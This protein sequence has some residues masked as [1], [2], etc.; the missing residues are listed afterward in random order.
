MSCAMVGVNVRMVSGA[1]WLRWKMPLLAALTL[2]T[3]TSC[4]SDTTKQRSICC[5][6]VCLWMT[7]RASLN[8]MILCVVVLMSVRGRIFTR[9]S[10]CHLVTVKCGAA[11]TLRAP[12]ITPHLLCWH[13]RWLRQNDS[14]CWKNTTGAACHSS[15]WQSVSAALRRAIT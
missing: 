12:A 1:M 4:A 9:K 8:S 6:C 5:L 2:L 14:A 15:L 10:P 11:L 3:S 7:K 13:R